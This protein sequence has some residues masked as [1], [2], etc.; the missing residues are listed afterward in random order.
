[1]KKEVV[2]SEKIPKPVAPY[3]QAVKAGKLV[4]SAGQVPI[5]INTGE[6]V[7]GDIKVQTRVTLENLKKVLESAGTSLNDVVKTTVF[8]TN[9]DRDCAGMNEV[10]KEYFSEGFPARSAVEV[11]KLWSDVL[12]EI[13]AIA[14]I[15]EAARD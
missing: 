12:V 8:L 4:F 13:E 11:S 15:P 3:S 9:F 2:V 1:M 10:Y 5:D 7:R 14:I 6:P